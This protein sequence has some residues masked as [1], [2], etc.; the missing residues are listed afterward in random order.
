M[1][2][3]RFHGRGGQGAVTGAYLL[4][5]AL[6]AENK[7]AQAFPSFGVERTGAPV[8]AFVRADD[9]PIRLREQIQNPDMLVIQDKTLL[10]IPEVF[11]GTNEETIAILNSKEA[12]NFPINF[13]GKLYCCD[14]TSL[15]V[16][17][18]GRPIFNTGMLGLLAK[19]T[20]IV[21]LESLIRAIENNFPKKLWETNIKLMEK[22]YAE[23]PTQ[24]CNYISK[25]I[26][27]M[28]TPNPKPTNSVEPA[29]TAKN[30]T[31]NWAT[32]YPEVDGNKCMKCGMCAN[33]C[34]EGCI[35]PD[36]EGV[37]RADLSKCKGCGLC[38]QVCPVKAITMKKKK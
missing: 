34:P 33:V 38:A 22:I 29:S 32:E 2:E 26:K 28:E 23:S 35:A 16:E 17:I 6:F 31:G 21:K 19:V 30:N 15:A 37:Y 5:H 24:P 14:I 25:L 7:Y 4:G 12:P 13:A 3:I 1:Q 36:A 8:E 18:L 27:H 10:D 9:R 20:G 11:A